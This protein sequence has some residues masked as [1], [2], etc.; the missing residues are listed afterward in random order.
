MNLCPCGSGKNYSE[1]CEIIIND[2]TKCPT[3]EKL[4]RARYTSY[5]VG[6]IDFIA[7]THN[8]SKKEDL[9]VEETRKWSEESK[10]R[11]LRIISVENG[12][13]GDDNGTVEFSASY[14]QN[15]SRYNHHEVSRFNRI[16]GRWYYMDGK[17]INEPIVRSSNKVGRNDPCPC[18]SGKK[19]KKCC[20]T[21]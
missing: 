21:A 17:I 20:M 19:F 7:D 1:C 13:S 14:E 16:D 18:G 10:W 5:V 8:P 9:S 3:A 12:T 2:I 4:M 6:K 11:G 15:G